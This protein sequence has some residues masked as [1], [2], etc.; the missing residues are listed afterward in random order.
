MQCWEGEVFELFP[1][2]ASKRPKVHK[3]VWFFVTTKGNEKRKKVLDRC[4]AECE[5]LIKKENNE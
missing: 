2:F 1:E 3:F 5:K 4:I